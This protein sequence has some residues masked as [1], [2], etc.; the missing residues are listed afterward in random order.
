VVDRWAALHA[1][2]KGRLKEGGTNDL[3]VAACCLV[4][5]LPLATGNLSDFQTIANEF[6][7]RLV[8][9]DL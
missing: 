3:W 6:P 7:L 2:F 5:D 9:P 8:H 4:L 1:R